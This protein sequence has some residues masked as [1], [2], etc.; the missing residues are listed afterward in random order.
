MQFLIHITVDE[1]KTLVRE[2]VSEIISETLKN[3]L[4]NS[5]VSPKEFMNV[6]EA[7]EFLNLAVNTLYEKTSNRTI[8]HFKSGA[9]LLFKRSELIKWLEEGKVS[10][11]AEEVLRQYNLR[12]FKH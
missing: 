8:P 9:K 1:F 10:T 4:N 6:K 11:A 12:R 7:S 3:T 2:T 5:E